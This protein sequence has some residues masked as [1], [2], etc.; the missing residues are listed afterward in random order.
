MV[1]L[2]TL[3]GDESL[4]YGIN[5]SGLITGQSELGRGGPL[6]YAYLY[7]GTMHSLGCLPGGTDSIGFAIN[8][9]G[10]TVGSSSIS[11]ISGRQHAFIYSAATGNSLIDPQSGWELNSARMTPARSSA[12][13]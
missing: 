8:N 5:D 10:T 7:D 1:D 6:R 13:V 12:L 2:G 11:S 3:G 9:V 4:A